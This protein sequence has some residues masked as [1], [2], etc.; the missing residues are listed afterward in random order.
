MA[1]CSSGRGTSVNMT[2]L[3]ITLVLVTVAVA[4]FAIW[5]R[6]RYPKTCLWVRQQYKLH[7]L[8]P[9]IENIRA[10]HNKVSGAGWKAILLRSGKDKEILAASE[11]AYADYMEFCTEH[12]LELPAD[13]DEIVTMIDESIEVLDPPLALNRAQERYEEMFSKVDAGGKRLL[14]VRKSSL[15]L[16]GNAERLINSLAKSPK[17]IQEGITEIGVQRQEFVSTQQ[18]GERAAANTKKELG[19]IAAGVAAGVGVAAFAPETAL[20]VATTFGTASTGT[21]IS[22][23][24]GAAAKN[25]ALAYIGGGAVASGGGGVMAG[26]ARLALAGPAGWAIAG[27]A[28]GV[29][30]AVHAKRSVDANKKQLAEIARVKS[31]TEALRELNAAI[32]AMSS[33]TTSFAKR[34]SKELTMCEKY[35]GLDYTTLN[36]AEKQ[37]LGVLVNHAIT[38]STLLNKTVDDRA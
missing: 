27:A 26:T 32:S 35:R 6:R 11:K 21:A 15:R 4:T 10:V 14:K 24:S 33:K 25:A 2:F 37:Q 20:W 17:V 29:T 22:A 19:G 34:F 8:E 23:L 12:D 3:G 28:I 5:F 13:H 9:Y 30:A 31:A 16:V 1:L 38:L 36:D 7:Q 18:F